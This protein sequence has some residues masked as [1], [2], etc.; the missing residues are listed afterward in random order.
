MGTRPGF[1]GCSLPSY[2]ECGE[3]DAAL[4]QVNIQNFWE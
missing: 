1:I 2:F 4:K 3:H